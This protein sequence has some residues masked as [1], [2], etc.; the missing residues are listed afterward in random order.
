MIFAL[1]VTLDGLVWAL[2]V[3]LVLGGTEWGRVGGWLLLG[4]K[5]VMLVTTVVGM[6]VHP[7]L[8]W[9]LFAGRY[10]FASQ[11]LRGAGQALTRFV[12]ELPQTGLG[13]LFAQWRNILGNLGRRHLCHG[14]ALAETHLCRGVA[15][16]LCE[17]VGEWPD[18]G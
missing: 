18:W 12:W 11:P 13:Y 14:T 7:K 9:G 5:G 8:A 6:L 16:M 10:R 4:G 17:Y 15:G 1:A 2:A 3:W